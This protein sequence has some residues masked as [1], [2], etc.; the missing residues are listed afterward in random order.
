[1]PKLIIGLLITI[2]TGISSIMAGNFSLGNAANSVE[3]GQGVYKIKACDDW[4][5]VNISTGATG[6][7]GA[8]EGMSALTGVVISS[9]DTTACAGTEFTIS[10]VDSENTPLAMYRTDAFNGL[11][12]DIACAGPT[13]IKIQIDD[14]GHLTSS[15]PASLYLIDQNPITA[16][17]IITFVR[18][19]ILANSVGRLNLQSTS[20]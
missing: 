11:C 18:P 15:I 6:E 12:S 4:V 13:E 3:F 8:P 2:V 14:F 16:E 9:L 17:F 5:K 20:L 7:F 19:A 10:A 1:M